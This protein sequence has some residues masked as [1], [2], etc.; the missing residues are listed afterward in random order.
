MMTTKP[1]NQDTYNQ[2]NKRGID[3]VRNYL[4][5]NGYF[6]NVNENYGIDIEAY[7]PQQHE[8]EIKVAWVDRWPENWR[9]IHIPAR[10]G[11]F[12]DQDRFFWV[13]SNDLTRAWKIAACHLKLEYIRQIPNKEINSG[14]EFYCVPIELAERVRLEGK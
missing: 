7:K 6:T 9:D 5:K 1:F 3:A 8:V 14:E 13:L 11:K 4:D 2:H 12:I 10:K